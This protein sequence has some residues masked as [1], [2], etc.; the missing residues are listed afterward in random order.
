MGEDVAVCVGAALIET[1]GERVAAAAAVPLCMLDGV[2]VGEGGTREGAGDA[3]GRALREAPPLPLTALV[4]LALRLGTAVPLLEELAASLG[5]PLE[6]GRAAPEVEGV[7]AALLVGCTAVRDGEG[8]PTALRLGLPPLPLGVALR[9]EEAL[10]GALAGCVAVR[11]RVP[12]ESGLPLAVGAPALC[13]GSGEGENGAVLEGAAEAV[14]GS[15]EALWVLLDA[16]V[17]CASADE[18][19][20][21]VAFGDTDAVPLPAPPLGVGAGDADVEPWPPL[22]PLPSLLL[23]AGDAEG[24]PLEVGSGDA[25]PLREGAPEPLALLLAPLPLPRAD[26]DAL[27][28]PERAAV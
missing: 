26:N 23:G 18:G 2:G 3:V 6:V 28:L 22:R 13:E 4:A 16:A 17:G 8:V 25:L 10:G 1:R 21:E 15:A 9:V 7:S 27:P 24:A 14:A 12:L 19:A 20:E 11:E 5:K